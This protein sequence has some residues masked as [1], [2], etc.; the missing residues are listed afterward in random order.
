MHVHV[1][2]FWDGSSIMHE[3]GE[4]PFSCVHDLHARIILFP[5]LA[6]D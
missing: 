2:P 6:G 5:L 3:L 1:S 4:S